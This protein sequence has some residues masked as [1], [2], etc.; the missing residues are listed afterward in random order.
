MIHES[1]TLA[2]WILKRAK[3]KKAD[4]ILVQKAIRAL[5]LLEG[6]SESPLSF[7]FKGGTALMLLLGSTK[8]L[9]IDIDIL[10][11]DSF[12]LDVM[13]QPIAISKGFLR[14][15][16]QHR[17]SQ[18][19]IQ[20]VH[21]KF[22]FDNVLKPGSQD[23]ILLDI[24]LEENRYQQVIPVI[25]ESPFVYSEGESLSVLVPDFNNMMGDKL[26]AFAP[27][28]VGI[29]YFKK[30]R[31]MGL[32]IIK[33]L[34]DL[35]TIFPHI[36][37]VDVL[38]RVFSD[39]AET[40]L[41]YRSMCCDIHLVLDD[42]FE[43]CYSICTRGDYGKAKYE[44]LQM[45][46]KQAD[47]YIFSERYHLEKAITHAARVAYIS[48]LIKTSNPLVFFN[49]STDMKDWIIDAP[50]QGLQKLKKTNPEAFYYWYK[51]LQM[52]K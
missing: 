16:P 21:Y 38:G 19:D 2:D 39:F 12:D 1:N 9:S 10:I 14:V 7:V 36:D 3:E 32:E 11:S 49:P 27:N 31:S 43:N 33:Q 20:K 45:G 42:I 44:I 46:I 30:E 48:V 40:E 4:P 13:L 35:G 23:Y 22:I 26:T 37:R 29:P 50:H 34:Y 8:R 51:C 6:L 15:E 41:G 47:A 17:D 52:K 25:I 28:T 24:L 5:L 18:G